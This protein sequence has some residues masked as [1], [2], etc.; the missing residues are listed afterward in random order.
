MR[1][2]TPDCVS[3]STHAWSSLLLTSSL[4]ISANIPLMQIT[5]LAQPQSCHLSQSSSICDR[6]PAV[7]SNS[8]CKKTGHFCVPVT[9]LLN[10]LLLLVAIP[11]VLEHLLSLHL[12]LT[13]CSVSVNWWIAKL[14]ASLL[15]Q[16]VLAEQLLDSGLVPEL[17][18]RDEQLE[19]CCS[20][21]R[22]RGTPPTICSGRGAL[23]TKEPKG[24]ASSCQGSE[25][26]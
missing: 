26:Q 10:G 2:H 24:G 17:E 22:K 16:Q 6:C 21:R 7:I 3:A 23:S 18:I 20:T 13:A 4:L 11:Q 19:R 8:A 15:Y 1:G 5:P 9:A 12:P 25:W 14:S